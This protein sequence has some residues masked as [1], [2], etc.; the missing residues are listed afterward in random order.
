MKYITTDKFE[1][2]IWILTII[3][4]LIVLIVGFIFQVMGDTPHIKYYPAW[5][6]EAINTMNI[7]LLI[8]ISFFGVIVIRRGRKIMK[9]K[10]YQEKLLKNNVEPVKKLTKKEEK[11]KYGL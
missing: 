5:W 11:D 7:I 10:E 8:L 6:D 2:K 9:T 4:L 3:Y 1:K